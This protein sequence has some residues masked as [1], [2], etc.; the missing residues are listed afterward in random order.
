MPSPDQTYLQQRLSD[1]FYN[2]N[3]WEKKN[4]DVTKEK[5][6]YQDK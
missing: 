2:K 3:E 6:K 4:A 1:F 5:K